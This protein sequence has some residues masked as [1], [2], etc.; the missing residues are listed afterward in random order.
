MLRSKKPWFVPL[1]L[2]IYTTGMFV[3]L[4]PRNNEVS[5]TE[6]VGTVVVAYAIIIVLYFLLKKKEKMA[7]EREDDINKNI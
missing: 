5:T 6:K 7:K 3:W 1:L 2:F 4:L